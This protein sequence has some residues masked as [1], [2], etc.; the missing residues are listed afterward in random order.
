MKELL[1]TNDAVMLSWASAVL[2]G[3]GI[4]TVVLDLHTSIL[5]GSIA[6]IPRRLMVDDDD[7]ARAKSVLDMARAELRRG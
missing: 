7:L 1:R 2:A 6:A 4:E 5:E 3:E